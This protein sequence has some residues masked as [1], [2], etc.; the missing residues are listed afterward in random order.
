MVNKTYALYKLAMLSPPW[1]CKAAGKSI[2]SLQKVDV[3]AHLG[4]GV[5]CE[6]GQWGSWGHFISA[7]CL[8]KGGLDHYSPLHMVT[9]LHVV[10]TKCF[11]KCLDGFLLLKKKVLSF[12]GEL[13]FFFYIYFIE[14][15]V[16]YCCKYFVLG[17]L[18]QQIRSVFRRLFIYKTITFAYWC[19]QWN[20]HE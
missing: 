7:C 2:K 11:L 10:K 3:T 20:V 4:Q 9:S 1:W 13:L 18:C 15:A 14:T 12:C 6:N 5:R 17:Y 19:R 8:Y 16:N